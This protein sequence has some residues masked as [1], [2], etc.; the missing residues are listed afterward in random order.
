LTDIEKAIC[1]LKNE[2][3][4][5][6]TFIKKKFEKL[7]FKISLEKGMTFQKAEE[8]V[9]DTLIKIYRNIL[10]FEYKSDGSFLAWLL[11]I[12]INNINEFYRKNKS[13]ILTINLDNDEWGTFV[14]NEEK[15][16]ES[17]QIKKIKDEINKLPEKDRILITQ[18]LMEIPYNIISEMLG[19]NPNK[20]KVRYHRLIKKVKNEWKQK[21]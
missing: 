8:T 12:H 6:L 15:E 16:V 14:Y 21:F 5:A 17:D 19:E 20:L 3:F 10:K 1:E 9:Q 13:R 2:N 4:A 18:R 7:L 11:K